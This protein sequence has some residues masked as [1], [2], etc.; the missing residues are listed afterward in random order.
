MV[1]SNKLFHDQLR[2]NLASAPP[3]S[4]WIQALKPILQRTRRQRGSR[5]QRITRV[6]GHC[7]ASR[8]R[9]CT[10]RSIVLS[11]K[12][13]M[14]PP[15]TKGLTYATISKKR[16]NGWW[17]E[18]TLLD[19]SRTLALCP[20]CDCFNEAPSL[21]STS[22]GNSAAGVTAALSSPLYCTTSSLNPSMA[23]SAYPNLPF[24]E[25][26]VKRFFVIAGTG[27]FFA[28][29]LVSSGARPFARFFEGNAG[30]CTNVLSS[31]T[32]LMVLE[33]ELSSD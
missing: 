18:P 3:A 1:C 7:S 12:P 26:A 11:P 22:L 32:F 14:I 28:S 8:A 25:S 6:E 29:R 30:L 2:W 27:S 13:T 4:M 33:T 24:S 21:P 19:T 10:L 31:G 20:A 5:E 17:R 23:P 9:D 15:N 16:D